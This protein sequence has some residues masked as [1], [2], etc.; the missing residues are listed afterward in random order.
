MNKALLK[1]EIEGFIKYYHED[2][3]IYIKSY[4]DKPHEYY[5]YFEKDKK[6]TVLYMDG[7]IN[8]FIK[9]YDLSNEER[10][11]LLTSIKDDFKLITVDFSKYEKK[12]KDDNTS[13]E[14]KI[15]FNYVKKTTE[16]TLDYIQESLIELEKN[17]INPV[18]QPIPNV[19]D[20]DPASLEIEKMFERVEQGINLGLYPSPP[21]SFMKNINELGFNSIKDFLMG[22]FNTMIVKVKD[23]SINEIGGINLNELLLPVVEA[24]ANKNSVITIEEKKEVE[25]YALVLFPLMF[26]ELTF[27]I[28]KAKASWGENTSNEA[29]ELLLTFM[30]NM[31]DDAK[32]LY[33]MDMLEKSLPS[34]KKEIE[35]PIKSIPDI[36]KI[37]EEKLVE[38]KNEIID[39]ENSSKLVNEETETKEKTLDKGSQ[40]IFNIHGNV[41]G[42]INH[43]SFK[44]LNNSNINEKQDAPK[45]SKIEVLYWIAGII[46]GAIAGITFIKECLK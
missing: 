31:S 14:W 45:R 16:N 29:G 25:D 35:K 21:L 38:K 39:Q 12:L 7:L 4:L 28:R 36:K 43:D 42:N 6:F 26:T 37:G 9:H 17:N 32:N 34:L 23:L 13:I 15:E 18:T 33:Q 8:K 5:W 1:S 2:C 46:L 41:T 19:N 24:F 11:K 22:V 44:E 20:L 30:G 40:T 27:D 10:V 3:I